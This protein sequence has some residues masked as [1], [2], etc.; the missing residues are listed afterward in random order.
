MRKYTVLTGVFL[1]IVFTSAA[2][3]AI[4]KGTVI[5]TVEKTNLGRSVIALIR[6]HDSVLVTF[7]RTDQEGKFELKQIPAGRFLLMAS[8]PSFA[9]YV[10]EIT[11]TADEVK[12]LG[13]IMLT[14][15]AKL[16]EAV[17]VQQNRAIVIKGDTIEYNADS[18]KVHTGANVRELLANLP[19]FQV[20]KDGQ[21][22]ARGKKV[23]K[24]LVDGEEFFTDDPAVVAENLRAD[25][26]DKVQSFDKK[27]D[28][29]AFTG[30]DDG[31]RI[32]TV[33]LV[34]KEGRK[35][36]YFGK[37]SAAGGTEERTS[38]EAM[39][40]YFKGK[41]KASVYGIFSN[42]GKVNLDWDELNRFGGAGDFSESSTTMSGG[43][44]SMSVG[45][46]ND[47][48]DFGS[49]MYAGEGIPQSLKAGAHFSNK[50]NNDVHH[51]AG[52]YSYKRMD[53][54]ATGGSFI[55]NILKDS[56]YY[57]R[58][59]HRS[60]NAQEQQA[61]SG[62]YDIK[63]DSL[64]S[65]RVRVDG[66]FGSNR[67]DVFTESSSMDEN[68]QAVNRNRRTNY[69]DAERKGGNIAMLWRQR[70]RKK[71]RTL[72]L[73]ASHKYMESDAIGFLFSDVR[74]YDG[75]GIEYEQDSIDQY[76]T[77]FSKAVT[78]RS[79]LVYTEPL[80]KQT[81]L[82][83]NYSF[84]RNLNASN[85]KSY[86]KVNGKYEMLNEAFS[87]TYSLLFYSNTGG[88]KIQ[89]T[90]KKMV[91][92]IGTN[93]G[94]SNYV[95]RDSTGK[96]VNQ[97][98]YTNL[99]PS[100]EFRY[101]FNQQSAFQLRYNGS[102]QSPS[103][104]QIQPVLQN[105]DPL[106]IMVGNPDLKQAFHHSIIA[107][108]NSFKLLNG[109][110]VFASVYYSNTRRAIVTSQQVDATGKRIMQFVNTNGN[111]TY[112]VN[113]T[114]NF[115]IKKPAV[116]LTL[117][118]HLN[119][120]R[121]TSFVN[122]EK[123]VSDNRTTS[124]SVSLNQYRHNKFAF[125]IMANVSRNTSVSSIYKNIKNAFWTQHY[126]LDV[127]KFI[128]QR[129]RIGSDISI[130]LREKV[131]AFDENNNV[132]TWNGYISYTVFR[133]RNGELRL[134]GFDLLN[135]Q[136]GFNRHFYQNSVTER[137]YEVLRQFFMLSLTWNFTKTPGAETAN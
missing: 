37:L 109:R 31:Q 96:K 79:R 108:F 61:F 84:N 25:A 9:D 44:I 128:T 19:G 88:A 131:D 70:M 130:N 129:L 59:Q 89:Y 105:N 68:L 73:S 118:M 136:K 34:L 53:V 75:A 113:G 94:V 124:G 6:Y 86:D 122:N 51:F 116:N 35:K 104:S 72:S 28:Q 50:W 57:F 93:A 48:V 38:N 30:V 90:T 97:L 76:K 91:A 74:L 133:N 132:T 92:N 95:Q 114:Y 18:F 64:S 17:I 83:L 60:V 3:N 26:I 77:A 121:Y 63:L 4:I 52:N 62:L 13:N 20:D 111:Y 54:D 99:F 135:Q 65:M 82:E 49:S 137:T 55:K 11:L 36:E 32:N 107:S 40:N 7:T 117:G 5:D 103:I 12:Q 66:L 78:T 67:S 127:T 115:A 85:Q 81:I 42:T 98:T 58:E 80:S 14:P 43:I 24:I 21:I 101:N 27:S 119:G 69:A 10:D 33:N 23:E 8:H 2:Q 106:N 22:I 125:R 112:T 41:K 110:H 134:Q 100:A 56:A 45:G 120:G 71:G 126:S 16:L 123:N 39:I 15:K 47:F 87:N 46:D 102:P 1:L 29:A